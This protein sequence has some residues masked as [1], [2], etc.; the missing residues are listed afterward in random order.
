MMSTAPARSILTFEIATSKPQFPARLT[1]ASAF[2]RNDKPGG[3]GIVLKMPE[4]VEARSFKKAFN[5]YKKGWE[6]HP[7]EHDAILDDYMSQLEE[8]ARR[9][10]DEQEHTEPAY[11]ALMILNMMWLTWAGRVKNDEFNGTS[12]TWSGV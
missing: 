9:T 2:L 10:R 5:G 8:F 6:S 1:R 12:F 3:V 4:D 11:G 7:K